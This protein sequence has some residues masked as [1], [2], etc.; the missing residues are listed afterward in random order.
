MKIEE[1]KLILK[2]AKGDNTDLYSHLLEVFNILI[3]H[4]PDDA[5]D[6]LEEVSYLKK[7]N[8]NL[9]EYLLLEKRWAQGKIHPDFIAQ[10]KKLFE[11]PKGEDGDD[12]V[13]ELPVVGSVPDLLTESKIFEWAGISFGDKEIYRLQ[14]SLASLSGK[15]TAGNLKFWGKINGT[16]KDYYVAEGTLEAGDDDGEEKG[17]DFE[18][19]GSGVNTYVYWVTDSSLN[20]WTQ[21]PDLSPKDIDAARSIKVLLTGDLEHEIITNPFFFGKEKNYLR[22]QIARISHGTTLIPRGI[23]K[24]SEPEEENG[25]QLE[26]EKID[27][28]DEEAKFVQPQ[29]EIQIDLSNWVHHPKSILNNNRTGH[30]EPVVPEDMEGV[31]PAD[32][33]KKILEKDPYVERIRSVTDDVEVDGIGSAWNLRQHNG[34]CRE[35]S[36]VVVKSLRWPGAHTI[37]KETTQYSIYVGNGLKNEDLSYYPVFPPMI[38]VDPVDQECQPEPTPLEAPVKEEA[39]AEGEGEEKKEE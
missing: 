16:K 17:P 24:L 10:A 28:E 26:I 18:A 31:E 5:L 3:L 19:R 12:E 22:A 39:Q 4:Y 7:K 20:E 32:L 35:H 21:L 11:L 6:K 34:S 15:T 33:L 27:V 9:E 14:K 25:P 1:L 13:V 2:N 37:W 23:F 36:V 29:T 38:P 8:A 30:L